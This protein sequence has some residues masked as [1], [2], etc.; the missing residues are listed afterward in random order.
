MA[1]APAL[2]ACSSSPPAQ[3]PLSPQAL[4]AVVDDPGVNRESLARAVDGL[5]ADTAGQEAG[6]DRQLGETRA[7]I[8]MRAGRIIAERYAPGYHENTRFAGGGIARSIT[9]VM[10]GMLVSDGRLRLNETAPVPAW[11]RPGDPRG[12]ITLRHLLQMRSGL[13]EEPGDEARMLFGAGR[14]DMAGAAEDQP[15]AAEPGARFQDDAASGIIL[16]DLA[17]RVLAPAGDPDA[18]RR[19]V[20]DYLRTRLFEP[21]LM[22]GIVPSYDARGTM[23]GGAMIDATARDF[24]RFGEFLRNRGAVH[25][26]QLVPRQWIDFMVSPSPREKQYGAGVWLNRAPTTGDARLFP[27]AGPRDMLA[28]LG[29]GGQAVLVAP[30]RKLVVVRLGATPPGGD[31]ALMGRLRDIVSLFAGGPA[32]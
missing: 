8:V 12:E 7:V 26:A 16:A 32:R 17:A 5:F 4:A 11:Q 31:A 28:A 15:L 6:G 1:L 23:N 9:A 13:R 3:A 27:Q 24:V 21:V 14:D 20:A 25:G 22:R 10:I 30:A 2:F 19:A 18:R 29:D